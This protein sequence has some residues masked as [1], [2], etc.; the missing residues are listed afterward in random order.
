M[1]VPDALLADPRTRL[2]LVRHADHLTDNVEVDDPDLTELGLFQAHRLAERL[3]ATG[4]A[5][6]YR[7]IVTSPLMRARRTAEILRSAVG[8]GAVALEVNEALAEWAGSS[9]DV[10][11]L[12][13]ESGKDCRP[14][15]SGESWN[16]FQQR[17]QT[18]LRAYGREPGTT[19]L[20]CHTGVVEVSF[21]EFAGLRQRSQRFAMAPRNASMTVWV[22]L[23][24]GNGKRWR[25]ETYNDS[26]HLWIDGS[27]RHRPEDFASYEPL[28]AVLEPD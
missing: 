4:E 1:T 15:G 27:L 7:H 8:S 17:V 6:Y 10:S 14:F 5:R 11:L 23:D 3:S 2:V 16:E 21:L 9:A 20:V 18:V 12:E 26:Q 19:M 25:L 24:G 13:R 28:W 22:G